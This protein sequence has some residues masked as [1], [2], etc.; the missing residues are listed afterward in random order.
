VGVK[1]RKPRA[2]QVV[3]PAPVTRSWDPL[4]FACLVGATIIAYLPAMRG[5]ILWD[6]TSHITRLDLQPLHGLWRIWFDLEATQQYYPLL[7]SA[8][9][10]EHRLWGDAVLGY[11]LTNVLL[12]ATSACLVV[13]IAKRLALKGA[14]LAGF[15]FALHPVMVEAVAWISEQK[16][17]LA[18]VLY[19]GSALVYLG[20]DE[21]RRRSRY[22]LATVLFAAA[23]LSKT[24]TATLPAVLLV[25]IWWRRG[26]LEWRRDVVPLVP[27]LAVGAGAGL[28]TA[29]VERTYIGAAGADF[30][31]SV[32]QRFLLAGRV[33]WFYAAKLVWP[34]DLTFLYPR[35]TLDA[36][37]WW[38]WLFPAGVAAVAVVLVRRTSRSARVPLDPLADQTHLVPAQAGLETGRGPGGPAY[39]NRG[40]L[41]AFLI[42]AGSLFPVLG[43]LNIYPFRYSF[44]A[45]HFQYLA[46]LGLII[47]VCAYLSTIA[48]QA[49]RLALPTV[50]GAVLGV[51]TWSQSGM[52]RYGE[53]LYRATLDRNPSSWLAHNNLGNT[54][55][56]D[57]R[58][59]EATAEFVAALQLKPDYSE[60]HLSLANALMQTPGH[61]QDAIGEYQ[62]AVRYDA[63]SER[64]HSNFSNALLQ[65]G[66]VPEAVAESQRALRLR[67]DYAEAHNNLGN[68]LL[69]SGLLQDATGE[70]ETALRLDPTLAEAHNNFG[71]AL[72]QSGR[73]AD[74]AAQFE[75]AVRIRP[76]YSG[77]YN[78]LGNALSELPGRLP[79]A[80]EAYRTALKIR[81]DFGRAHNNLGN[82]LAKTPGH[83]DEAVA[84]YREALRIDPND[85]DAKY[86]LAKLQSRMKP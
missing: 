43:F 15:V 59:Q 26:R 28:F 7:H 74:A 10:L 75:I 83:E 36:S 58:T 69:Q 54:L 44:V 85:A 61:L 27:W 5:G 40:A 39:S 2:T 21:S 25:V 11:H 13:L 72:A 66:R 63:K 19:L 42:F 45:D 17:T 60:A 82:A 30:S 29:W 20:F 50:L 32:V 24:V 53:T 57:G 37:V 65:A 14:W 52:Y 9:W 62:D 6:D 33:I 68:A 23:L 38:Q 49:G 56:E 41:A 78:N 4:L 46:S 35:W 70:Y 86:N 73:M 1:G 84:E 51:L 47:P 31:L 55:L 48:G 77:A 22:V 64:A 8:F 80:I 16:S 18:G 67:P 81:P 76:Q 79:D 3:A 71:R 34:V 12:H